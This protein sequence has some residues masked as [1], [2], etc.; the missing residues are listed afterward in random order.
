MIEDAVFTGDALFMPDS[1]TGRCDFPQ[2]S[3][4]QLYHS[5][6]D[7]LYALPDE[8]RIFTGHDY[9]PGGRELR[10][11]CTVAESKERNIQLKAATTSA[12]FIAFRKERDKKLKAPR[13]LLPSIQININGGMLPQPE[14]GGGRYLKLPLTLADE[15]V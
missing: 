9:Q 7:K 14:A 11:T 2:G 15:P 6:H 1:G 10:F 13:L 12:E 4:E 5:I 3:A 8:T